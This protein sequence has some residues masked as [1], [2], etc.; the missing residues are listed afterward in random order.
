MRAVVGPVRVL[1]SDVSD[2]VRSTVTHDGNV[3]AFP[4]YA[5]NAGSVWVRDL[6]SGRER[7]LA[8]TTRRTPLNPVISS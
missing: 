5:A 3:L 2:T 6:R 1:R 8:A 7:Q 4:R